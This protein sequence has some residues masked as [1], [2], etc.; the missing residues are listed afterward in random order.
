MRSSPFL[1]AALAV[2]LQCRGREHL[3]AQSAFRAAPSQGVV[4]FLADNP[5]PQRSVRAV[6]V[7]T[8]S[9]EAGELELL[10]RDSLSQAIAEPFF[11]VGG[12]V[13]SR[14]GKNASLVRAFSEKQSSHFGCSLS[15]AGEYVACHA[16]NGVHVI[17]LRTQKTSE[18]Q[19]ELRQCQWR[20][21]SELLCLEGAYQKE[22]RI[23]ALPAGK[24][25]RQIL[26]Q[27]DERIG[28]LAVN[29]SSGA[30]AWSVSN[31]RQQKIFRRRPA[32]SAD[33][34]L[35]SIDNHYVFSL[36]IASNGA[37]AARVAPRQRESG[38]RQPRNIWVSREFNGR[39]G[40]LLTLAELPAPGF[41]RGAGFDGVES[42]D[43][44]PDGSQLAILMSGPDDCRMVDEGGNVACRLNV[45]VYDSKTGG[46]HQLTHFRATELHTLAWREWQS[47]P[48]K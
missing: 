9:G 44:A 16:G 1:I 25:G 5:P 39:A 21:S 31:D 27:S 37:V 33:E 8:T 47:P 45:H 11:S 36:R 12:F 48:A 10:S 6:I 14:S 22:R 4:V 29:T 26:R 23:V 30:F 24:R 35:G 18:E 28:Q 41:F 7:D 42:F 34:L 43:F 13:V 3:G 46:L 40:I 32:G 20:R 15:P 2:L 38:N 17:D 19:G